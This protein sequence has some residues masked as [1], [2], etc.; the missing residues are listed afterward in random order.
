MSGRCQFGQR[1]AGGGD[2]RP[3]RHLDGGVRVGTGVTSV[4]WWGARSFGCTL[5]VGCSAVK[6]RFVR[7][8]G[9]L[10]D[11]VHVVRAGS[12]DPE[13]VRAAARRMSAVHGLHGASVF[14]PRGI[15][16]D[17]LAQQPPLVRFAGLTVLG[18]GVLRASGLRL[19]PTGRNPLH[20]TVVMD[21][22]EEG[23][24]VLC[25][26]V[27]VLTPT[28][29]PSIGARRSPLRPMGQG[30]VHRGARWTI[31]S[32]IAGCGHHSR[33]TIS[34][35]WLKWAVMGASALRRCSESSAACAQ[36]ASWRFEVAG[37]PVR[38]SSA[39][40]AH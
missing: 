39:R 32:H 9:G 24:A 26:P 25:E 36:D 29:A 14:A 4:A 31:L 2:L 15:A 5:C 23:V 30:C 34:G 17:E 6:T 20:L 22:L 7:S 35:S 13:A 19:E 40:S 11:D 21:R 28:G 1:S 16:L 38:S 37:G 8:G 18:V 12:L 3:D 27:R 10:D 33:V